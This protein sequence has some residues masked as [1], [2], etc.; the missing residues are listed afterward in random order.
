MAEGLVLE[1]LAVPPLEPVDL[2]LA[3]GTITVLRGPS[4]SGKTRLLRAI[5]DLEPHRGRALLDGVPA[6]AM[7][8]P[9]WRRKVAWLPAEPRWWG[10]RA[11]DHFPPGVEA[12]LTAAGLAATV[13]D[14][15]LERL[16]SGQLQRLALL[17]LLARGP[18]VLLLDE[19]TA[20]LDPVN[21]RRI[22]RLVGEHLARTGAL[23]L[24]VTHDEEQAARLG[25]SVLEIRGRRL[26]A[27]A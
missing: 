4:G 11:R 21:T 26:E 8:A 7:P 9:Q 3:P 20:R 12:G 27:A 10:A 17:R 23:A 24:W 13:L 25:G 15:P 6:E 22:E 16:S 14:E 2:H 5:A 1:G 19:P 18:R